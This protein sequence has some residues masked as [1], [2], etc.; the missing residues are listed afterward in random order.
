M[1]L[2]E[3]QEA[4]AVALA[5]LGPV[6]QAQQLLAPLQLQLRI[7]QELHSSFPHLSCPCCCCC[8]WTFRIRRMPRQLL[9]PS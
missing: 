5:E 6:L 9:W 4:A 7:V 3:Q 1:A 8:H 2:Q